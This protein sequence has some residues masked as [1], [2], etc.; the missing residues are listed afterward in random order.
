MTILNSE[1]AAIKKCEELSSQIV[2]GNWF[3]PDFG[4]QP[5]NS[6]K[7]KESLYGEGEAPPGS[8]KD[9]NVEWYPLS[10]ISDCAQ[11]FSDGVESND[12]MQG[13]LGDCWF[14]FALSLLAIKDYLLRGE[15]NE[16]C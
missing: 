4:S 5:N 7:N 13:C 11:F 14:I 12:V 1:D 16:K 9:T 10:K 3:D 2:K 6:N 15:F 8:P